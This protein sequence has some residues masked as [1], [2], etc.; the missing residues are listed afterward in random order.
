MPGQAFEVIKASDAS[1]RQGSIKTLGSLS[2]RPGALSESVGRDGDSDTIDG[3]LTA[4]QFPARLA[5][6]NTFPTFSIHCIQSAETSQHSVPTAVCQGLLGTRQS[7]I[8]KAWAPRAYQP[9]LGTWIATPQQ[10]EVHIFT[11]PL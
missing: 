3:F 7:E 11:L 10:F 1:H 2:I 6:P 4:D 8:N 9:G 5:A